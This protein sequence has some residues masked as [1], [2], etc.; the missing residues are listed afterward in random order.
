MDEAE[1]QAARYQEI[2]G[3]GNFYLELQDHPNIPDQKGVIM[4][5]FDVLVSADRMGS[6]DVSLY[7]ES[8]SSLPADVPADIRSNLEKIAQQP[9]LRSERKYD[10]L[11]V[12][13]RTVF[14]N[15]DVYAVADHIIS[16][17]K[18]MEFHA[19][20]GSKKYTAHQLSRL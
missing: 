15:N 1:A 20:T 8:L 4:N 14:F 11:P 3:K 10:A 18:G 16:S 17:D 2:F 12:A 9:E 13:Y 7:M 19:C 6:K 5:Q